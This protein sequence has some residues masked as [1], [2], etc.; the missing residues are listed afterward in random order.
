MI[1]TINEGTSDK[2]FLL[3]KPSLGFLTPL[4]DQAWALS[5]VLKSGEPTCRKNP[6][7]SV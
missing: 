3:D 5:L 6:A 1:A 2:N 7:N 4:L